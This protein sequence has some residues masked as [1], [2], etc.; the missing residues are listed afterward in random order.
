[1]HIITSPSTK[2]SK[3]I[4]FIE[5]ENSHVLERILTAMLLQTMQL[6]CK[7]SCCYL[8]KVSKR[9]KSGANYIIIA[10]YAF[11]IATLRLGLEAALVACNFSSLLQM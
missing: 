11:V 6:Y 3:F 4:Y 8:Y 5:R 9:I 1:M 7:Q 10:V 2:H